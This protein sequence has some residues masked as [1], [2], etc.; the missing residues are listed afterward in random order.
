MK[1]IHSL[2]K[3]QNKILT[4]N[5]IIIRKTGGERIQNSV[6]CISSI[7]AKLGLLWQPES[8]PVP[9]AMVEKL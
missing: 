4:L 6:C 2:I 7:C 9:V 5:K 1:I 3:K 8:G